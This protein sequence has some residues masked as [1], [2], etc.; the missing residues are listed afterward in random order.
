MEEIREE[1]D[2][3]LARA[4]LLGYRLYHTRSINGVRYLASRIQ[5]NCAGTGLNFEVMDYFLFLM[6]RYDT[7][8]LSALTLVLA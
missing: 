5:P 6:S 7:R 8:D 2:S 3:I 4:V 1:K